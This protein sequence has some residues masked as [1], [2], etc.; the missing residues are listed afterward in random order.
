MENTITLEKL[1]EEIRK[2]LISDM[3]KLDLREAEITEYLHTA[4]IPDLLDCY[5]FYTEGRK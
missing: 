1:L 3:N 2:F 5:R 4:P